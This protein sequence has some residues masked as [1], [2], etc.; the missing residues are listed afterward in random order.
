MVDRI[1]VLTDTSRHLIDLLKI[2][3]KDNMK[4]HLLKCINSD[5]L[6]NI[7]SLNIMEHLIQFQSDMIKQRIKG[8][9]L[10]VQ[11]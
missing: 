5:E 10:V 11:K 6:L 4:I 3:E 1:I 2:C 8:K 9:Q 7:N